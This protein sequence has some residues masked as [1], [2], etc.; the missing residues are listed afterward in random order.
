MDLKTFKHKFHELKKRGFVK[1]QRTGNTGVGHTL[2]VLLGISENNIALSDLDVAELKGHR[3][4]SNS[5]IT[6]FT[7]DRGAWL[8]NQLQA[9][10]KYGLVDSSGRPNLYMTLYNGRG[11]GSL[12]LAVD[13]SGV[14]VSDRSGTVVAKWKLSDLAQSF[15]KKFPALMYVVAKVEVR[16]GIEWF[17][18]ESATLLKGTSSKKMLEGIKKGWIA[19]DLR[20]HDN[21]GSTRNHGT[22]FRIMEL[23]F[24]KLFEERIEI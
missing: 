20:L 12:S 16:G 14:T 10:H 18:Y 19:V 9:I 6:L 3:K 11:G 23:D 13:S 5:L 24:P 17:H 15:E 8:V 7:L 21:N 22:G 2:E 4:G 1:S